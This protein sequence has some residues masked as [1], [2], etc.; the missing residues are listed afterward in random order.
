MSD[1]ILAHA[2]TNATLCAYVLLSGRWEYWL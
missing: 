2:V 1:V